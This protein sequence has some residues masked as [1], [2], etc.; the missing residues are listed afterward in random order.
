MDAVTH[1][2]EISTTGQFGLS[3]ANIRLESG[4]DALVC[5]HD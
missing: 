3:V 5:P 4:G 1:P 2:F